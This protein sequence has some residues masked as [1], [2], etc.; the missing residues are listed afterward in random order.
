[1]SELEKALSTLGGVGTQRAKALERL[2][3][4]TVGDL[5]SHF[6]RRYEDRTTCKLIGQLQHGEM[7]Y[8]CAMVSTPATLSFVRKGMDLVKFRV[9]DE[10]GAL[11][12]TFFNQSW[13][14]NQFRVGQ[15]YYFYARVDVSNFQI[16]MTSPV[17]EPEGHQE[18][19]GCIVPRYALTAGLSNA[20][21]MKYMRQCLPTAVTELVDCLP[22]S[23]RQ[24][25]Q[26]CDVAQ[27]YTQIH[28]PQSEEALETA[29]HRLAFEE[30]FLFTLGLGKLRQR[31]ETVLV[32]PCQEIDMDGF[33]HRLP[34]ALTKAQRRSIDQALEDCCS[35]RPMNRLC[36]GDVG[37]GKTMVAAACVYFMA[38]NGR[39]S[40]MMAPTEIL[41]QQHFRGLS[42]LLEPLGIRCALLTGSMTAKTK[43]DIAKQLAQGD[44]AFVIGTHAL[45][46]QGVNFDDLA[47]VITDEQHRFG[48][49]QRAALSEKG[50]H[51]HTLV[52]SATPIPRTLALMLY[53]D[54]D[55][56]VIDEL[57][58]GRQEI[59][60]SLVDSRYHQRIYA[61]L[62][63][64]VDTGRQAYIVCPAVEEG[65]DDGGKKAVT[66]YV[67]ELSQEVFPDLRI[68]FVHGKL[69]AKEKEATM[70]TFAAGELDI[71]VA[72]TVIEVGVDVP[73][74]V[75]MVIENAEQFGL[76]QLHQLR[77]RVGRGEHQS[78]CVLI[79]DNFAPETR[80][81]LTVMT[82]TSDGF[83]IAQED[84]QLRGAGDFFGQRQHGLS[85]L[86]V[87]NL[88]CDAQLMQEAQEAGKDLL[89]RDP[90]LQTCP[91]VAQR[92]AAL[93][94][95]HDGAM[96]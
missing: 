34:F 70:T 27:A 81:R 62:R 57:P 5:V 79:S 55:V 71:L 6:P 12:I 64:Q 13:L 88:G 3:L 48:V 18:Q 4:K 29:R 53:G 77:G 82:Q 68:G 45:I 10:S 80:A 95:Q 42:N 78:Y 22:L 74:A 36:Q 17:W 28:F 19:T 58:P 40:A 66:Q 73:N 92:V 1:M 49:A 93:F 87:A 67:K 46:S 7:A 32:P 59:Q 24:D 60:T 25:H 52:M 50:N 26:L 20:M 56:S 2:G 54:L 83:R 86:Q 72:T 30:L 51:P 90:D 11:G 65:E 47:L 41:A 44:I 94:A 23:L 16:Q 91:V 76:S 37:A 31:R 84:L 21:V 15:T 9:V 14:K 33:Y 69:K 38:Q 35:G 43:R 61:F 89:S 75:V 8:V 85:Q 39:Q 63:K 96:N